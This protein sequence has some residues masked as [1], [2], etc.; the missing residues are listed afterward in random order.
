MCSRRVG[1]G[2]AGSG[3]ERLAPVLALPRSCGQGQR[4]LADLAGTEIAIALLARGHPVDGLVLEERL[5]APERLEVRSVVTLREMPHPVDHVETQGVGGMAGREVLPTGVAPD[6]RLP[7]RPDRRWMLTV[8]GAQGEA[9][10]GGRRPHLT[11][12]RRPCT[13]V[14]RLNGGIGSSGSSPSRPCPWSIAR[15]TA[16]LL[17][18]PAMPRRVPRTKSC[19]AAGPAWCQLEP[20]SPATP[21]RRARA[22][23]PGAIGA[24]ASSQEP[25]GASQEAAWATLA[26]ARRPTPAAW[27]CSATAVGTT[28]PA[29]SVRCP[30]RRGAPAHHRTRAQPA[31]P[32]SSVSRSA[33]SEVGACAPARATRTV[34]VAT[35][36]NHAQARAPSSRGGRCAPRVWESARSATQPWAAATLRPGAVKASTVAMCAASP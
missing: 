8:C 7:Q 17:R 26:S 5:R 16:A 6:E 28:L 31:R 12:R 10:T 20:T 32:A 33:R 2:V 27:G 14:P 15:E 19:C 13:F 9:S 23:A 30:L 24:S 35:E 1:A 25:P 11:W 4:Q 22:S 34:P 18:L 36:G 21:R 29:V 3:S